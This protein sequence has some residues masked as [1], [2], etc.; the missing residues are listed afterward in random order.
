MGAVSNFEDSGGHRDHMLYLQGAWLN[1]RE[2]LRHLRQTDNHEDY[3]LLR[4]ASKSVNVVTGPIGSQ[5][6]VLVTLDGQYL[7]ESNKG[8]DVTIE[9]DGKSYLVLDSP[10]MHNV[11]ILPAYGVHDLKLSPNDTEFE[12]FAFTFGVY[13]EG[14]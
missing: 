10:R 5:T 14:P 12:I 4:F 6:K 8:E 7:N 3:M 11:V 9:Q 1:G 13:A 2:S